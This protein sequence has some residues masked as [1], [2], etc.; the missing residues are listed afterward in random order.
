M[1]TLIRA[2]CCLALLIIVG[3]AQSYYAYPCGRVR[4][5]YCPPRT[6]PYSSPENG[7]CFDSIGQI[8]LSHIE[9]KKRPTKTLNNLHKAPEDEGINGGM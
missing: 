7:G 4:C 1:I 9:R 8:Y 2:G 6:L 5:S 3:C